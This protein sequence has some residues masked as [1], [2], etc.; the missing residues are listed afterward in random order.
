MKPIAVLFCLALALG[1]GACS[2]GDDP[3]MADDEREIHYV[4]NSAFTGEHLR[5]FL[6]LEDGTEVSVDTADGDA[7]DTQPSET[8]I[9]DHVARDWTFLKE[10]GGGTAL[11]YALVSWDEEDPADYLMAGWWAQFH[12][13]RPP[14]LSL[15]DSDQWAI[16]DGP[17]IDPSAP[18]ELPLGGRATYTGWAGGLYSYIPGGD[19]GVELLDEYRGTIEIEADFARS[20]LSG[21]IGCVGDLVT[22]RAHFGI[23]LGDEVRDAEAV[24][25][26]YE[27][28][29]GETPLNPDG[30][31]QGADVTVRH[32]DRNVIRSDGFWGG[33]V[34]N[35]PDRDGNPRLLTGFS[36]AGFD[37][38]DGGSGTFLGAFVG[39]SQEFRASGSR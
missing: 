14:D 11:A 4:R 13:Q 2:S 18:P 1:A 37:E 27:L 29:L 8:L 19:R 34:S 36:S 30:T 5:V 16:V 10:T 17:E 35:V 38:A 6:T 12:G 23:F 39:L 33:A 15:A 21:C 22:R 24:A 28:H 31:F 32:K 3:S 9:P 20:A 7:I 25:A 26:G